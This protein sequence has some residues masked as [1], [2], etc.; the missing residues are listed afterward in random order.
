MILRILNGVTSTSFYLGGIAFALIISGYVLEVVLRYFFNAPTSFTSDFTQWFF[1]AMIML[2][3][4]EVTYR[5]GHVIISFFLEKMPTDF[6]SKLERILSFAGFVICIAVCW[7]CLCETMRQ[8]Q[9]D[10]QTAWNHPIPKW[11]ISVFIPYGMGLT[12][13]Q[14]LSHALKR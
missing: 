2:C 14:F 12:G 13:L 4:P 3:I 7:I 1:A 10:I 6:R 9:I 5:K 8:Y 11:W